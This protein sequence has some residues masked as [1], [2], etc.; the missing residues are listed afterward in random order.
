MITFYIPT[1]LIF[2]T[3]VTIYFF[4]TLV[5]K[6]TL[7]DP[8]LTKKEVVVIVIVL[9]AIALTSIFWPTLLVFGLL[10]KLIN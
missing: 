8:N 6:T 7:K 10:K 3:L 4:K 5:D 2:F 9:L 1:V